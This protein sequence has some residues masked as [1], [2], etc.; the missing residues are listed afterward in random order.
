MT[1]IYDR[2]LASR[3]IVTECLKDYIDTCTDE[4]LAKLGK[5]VW[6]GNWKVL[7]NNGEKW[8]NE[9]EITPMTFFDEGIL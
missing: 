4:A 7:D 8:Y 3:S 9:F 6:G 5:M 1:N 2:T